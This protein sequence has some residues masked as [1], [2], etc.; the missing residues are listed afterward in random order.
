MSRAMKQSG[1]GTEDTKR[2]LSQSGDRLLGRGVMW[3]LYAVAGPGANRR[4]VRISTN[5][6]CRFASFAYYAIYPTGYRLNTPWGISAKRQNDA[7]CRRETKAAAP[8]PPPAR[9]DRGA[10]T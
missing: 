7:H 8:G 10:G 3:F 6:R 2:L 9:T 5:R 1:E 4:P